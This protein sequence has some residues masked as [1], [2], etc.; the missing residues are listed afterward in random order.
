MPPHHVRS[1]ADHGQDFSCKFPYP[2]MPWDLDGDDL[3]VEEFTVAAGCHEPTRRGHDTLIDDGPFVEGREETPHKAGFAVERIIGFRA[4]N[5]FNVF[6]KRLGKTGIGA[7]T[8]IVPVATSAPEV[9]SDPGIPATEHSPSVHGNGS[10]SVH[11][12]YDNR[13]GRASVRPSGAI[14]P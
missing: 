11:Q 8:D 9:K 6:N 7:N 3:V 10:S 4:F 2:G 1:A 12:M 5:W 14:H 13:L